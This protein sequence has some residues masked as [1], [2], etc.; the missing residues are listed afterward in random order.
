MNFIC[1]P[2]NL[3]IASRICSLWIYLSR[4]KLYSQ[5]QKLGTF[6]FWL[7]G[8]AGDVLMP[9]RGTEAELPHS[10]LLLLHGLS[11]DIQ[12]GGCNLRPLLQGDKI[13][14]LGSFSVVL[15]CL[16]WFAQCLS[17]FSEKIKLSPFS[18]GTL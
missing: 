13:S 16:L 17:R 18:T 3:I 6:S 7:K 12:A 10:L 11:V 5:I 1:R 8:R 14:K 9:E 2:K 15:V 4:V